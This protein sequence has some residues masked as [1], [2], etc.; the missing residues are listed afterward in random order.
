MAE[1]TAAVLALGL[2][3]AVAFMTRWEP[4]KPV[5]PGGLLRRSSLASLLACA[6]VGAAWSGEGAR[7]WIDS[8]EGLSRAC[9][10]MA[11]LC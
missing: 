9:G 7:V 6:A 4:R 2:G 3:F 10:C 1:L 5:V 11:G 8:V